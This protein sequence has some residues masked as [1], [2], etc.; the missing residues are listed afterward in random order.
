M[1]TSWANKSGLLEAIVLFSLLSGLAFGGASRVSRHVWETFPQTLNSNSLPVELQADGEQ[2]EWMA[3]VVERGDPMRT[4]QEQQ[5][6]AMRVWR[7]QLKTNRQAKP[8]M[9]LPPEMNAHDPFAEARWIPFQTNL[10]VDLGPGD[11][12]RSILFSYRYN[13][14]ARANGWSGSSVT[15]Q[16]LKP[17]LRIVNPANMIL[18]QPLIQLQGYS[19]QPLA[20]VRYD[21]INESGAKVVTDEGGFPRSSY[22][23]GFPFQHGE[24]YFTC[25]D[26]ELSLGTNTIVLRCQD[27]AGNSMTTNLT[28]VFSTVGDT[29]PPLLALHWPR[30]GMNLAMDSFTANGQSDDPTATMEGFIVGAGQ[31]NRI[32]GFPERNGYFWFE[33]IPLSLGENQ[34]TLMATDIAGNRSITNLTLHG[35]EGPVITL[36]AIDPAKLWQPYL[37]LTGKVS[38]A[39]NR[40]WINGVQATVNASGDWVAERV[41][42]LSP[43]GGTATFEITA[44]P[45][46][47]TKQDA[48]AA[49]ALLAAQAS[50]GSTPMI[51]N[52]ATPACG[53]FQLRL[54]ST[55]GRPFIIQAST[56]LSDW[57]P[58][59]TNANPEA[60]FDFTDFNRE[61][62]PCRFFRVV[63]LK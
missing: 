62:Y 42:V 40:V 53:T 21:L 52:A 27:E 39:K 49:P 16:T 59:L 38:P 22:T 13:G 5:D 54:S 17:V 20:R 7:T 9:P 61:N 12:D 37:K 14:Q 1:N 51:L 18:P 4:W 58:L 25:F 34:L 60:A 29:N 48:T 63:P 55:A 11:G 8:V 35:C 45:P 47:G 2:P 36:D 33:E 41:P 56:N 44:I 46:D 30:P 24:E 6:R 43:N 50:L 32:T 26:I 3:V 15:V 57:I 19:S 31:T 10:T 23:G 28:Y